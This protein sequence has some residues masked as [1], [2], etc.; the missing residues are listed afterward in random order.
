MNKMAVTQE[1]GIPI[2]LTKGT[3]VNTEIRDGKLQLRESV[4]MTLGIR[5]LLIP[6]PGNLK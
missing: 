2:D 4:L 5:S 6:V 3:F 1:I